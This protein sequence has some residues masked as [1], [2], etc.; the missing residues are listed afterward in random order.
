M[1]KKLLAITETISIL[2]ICA[3]DIFP[4]WETKYTTP[5]DL[6]CLEIVGLLSWNIYENLK[7]K[8]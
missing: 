6:F 2:L 4:H 8:I 7:K 3:F 5:G 1:Y